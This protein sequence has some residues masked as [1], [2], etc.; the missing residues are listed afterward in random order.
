MRDDR[1]RDRWFYLMGAM[2]LPGCLYGLWLLYREI[3]EGRWLYPVC[4]LG[5]AAG[6]AIIVWLMIRDARNSL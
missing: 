2:S 4:Y 3:A 6:I 5:S 1:A